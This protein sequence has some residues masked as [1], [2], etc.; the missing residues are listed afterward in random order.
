MQLAG[1][2]ATLQALREALSWPKLYKAVAEQLGVEWPNA[3][4]LHGPPGCGKTAA[5]HAVAAECGAVLHEVSVATIGG[6][7]AGKLRLASDRGI[8]STQAQR[9]NFLVLQARQSGGCA[10][11]LLQL[12]KRLRQAGLSLSLWT[13]QAV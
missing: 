3:L 10:R 5:V 11:H 7:F 4:L 1:M 13:R 6:A 12:G 9:C 2:D 8:G